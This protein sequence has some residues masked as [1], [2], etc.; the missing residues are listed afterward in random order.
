MKRRRRTGKF[1]GA[2]VIL[3]AL[4]LTVWLVLHYWVFTLRDVTVVG[5]G[6]IPSEEIIRLSRIVMGSRLETLDEAQLAYNIES[7]GRLAFEGLEID[8][9]HRAILNVRQ[10]THDAITLQGSKILVLDADGYVVN[11]YDQVPSESLPYVT[12]LKMTGYTIGR[13]IDADLERI[14]AMGAV[15]RALQSAYATSYVSEINLEDPDH[16][17]IISRTGICVTLGDATNMDNKI[18]WME[19]ALKDLES[20]GQTSGTLDVASGTKADYAGNTGS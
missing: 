19:S 11:V 3:A 18:L 12:H 4:A 20:R 9:P 14:Q 10:R 13:Q 8:Y 7:D 5:N 15:V 2:V 17:V 1:W 16:I 6:D